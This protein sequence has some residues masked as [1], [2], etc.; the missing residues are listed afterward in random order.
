MPNCLSMKLGYADDWAIAYQSKDWKDI[1]NTLSN[2]AT[3]L[4]HFFDKWYLK[5]NTTK[6][7][8]TIFHLNNHEANKKLNVAIDGHI[9]PTDINPKYLGV[10]LDRSLTYKKHLEGTANKIA[11][12][13][14][15]LR[16]LTSTSWGAS[17]K[18]LRTSALALC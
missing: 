18:V 17:P 4:K 3:T 16:K 1:E 13:N 8:S 5:M 2:D 9:L 14:C 15:L 10:T 12:R 11:K 6:S 7:V